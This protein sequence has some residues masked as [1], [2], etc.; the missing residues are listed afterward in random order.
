MKKYLN[1][2]EVIEEFENNNNLKID[3]YVSSDYDNIDD[4]HEDNY[5]GKD[6]FE[7]H[8]NEW[9]ENFKEIDRDILYNLLGNYKYYTE[10]HLKRALKYIVNKIKEQIEDMKL[11]FD[12]VYF[13]TFPSKDGVKSGGDD[14]R[15]LLELVAL[16]K[17]EKNHIISDLDLNINNLIKD[18]DAIVFLDDIVGSGCTLYGNITH[19][20]EKL[21]LIN[22]MNIQL[23][24]AIIAGREKKIQKKIKQIKKESGIQIELVLFDK[25]HKCF[26]EMSI[27]EKE[28]RIECKNIIEIYEQGIDGTSMNDPKSNILGFEKNQLLVSFRYNTPNNTLCNF[29][30]PSSTSSPLFVRTSYK[31]PNI[32][33]IRK[34]KENNKTNAYIMGRMLKS[35]DFKVEDE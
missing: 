1:I 19:A 14:I 29:W 5:I 25:C 12:N 20:I 3:K 23:F 33:M 4:E 6:V 27:F 15:S 17:I 13:I 35:V 31:R 11:N 26:D 30:K 32:N 2:K 8:I 22:H 18:S 16:G 9:I 10:N 7:T 24:V 34:Y 21:D 28:E